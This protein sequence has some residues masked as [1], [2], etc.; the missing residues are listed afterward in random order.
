MWN[1]KSEGSK[2]GKGKFRREEGVIKM[3]IYLFIITR[4]KQ[5]KEIITAIGDFQLAEAVGVGITR[6]TD[7]LWGG[8]GDFEE[9]INWTPES[10]RIYRRITVN[11]LKYTS[12][13]VGIINNKNLWSN[14]VITMI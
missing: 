1:L 4:E 6:E 14:S 2:G 9:I 8:G 7:I 11:K 5:I 12:F 13:A 10:L 3:I